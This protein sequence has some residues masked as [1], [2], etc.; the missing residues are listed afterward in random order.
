LNMLEVE[1]NPPWRN[2]EAEKAFKDLI[3]NQVGLL[4]I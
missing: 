3:S 1:T 2:K 4:N